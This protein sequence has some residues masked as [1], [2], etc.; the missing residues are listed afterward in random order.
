MRE[1]FWDADAP[2]LLH[3]GTYAGHPGACVAALVNLDILERERL[4]ERVAALEP[5][6]AR[7]LAPLRELPGIAEIRQVGLA[8]AVELDPGLLAANPGLPAAA[9][10]AARGHGV[11]S[12][13]LRGV[14][15]Q[16]SPPFV[17]TEDELGAIVDGVAAGIGEAVGAS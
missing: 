3:G 5:H 9:V 17:V 10:A 6:L 8:A 2:P 1:P 12:R 13:A 16:I 15:L 11:L 7:L 14:A 4:V